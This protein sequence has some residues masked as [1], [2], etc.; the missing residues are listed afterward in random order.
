MQ[1]GAVSPQLLYAEVD[2]KT[3]GLYENIVR[4]NITTIELAHGRRLFV[5]SHS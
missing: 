5:M 1:E 4:M 2:K 3:D